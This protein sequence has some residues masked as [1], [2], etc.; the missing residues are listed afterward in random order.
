MSLW[1][2]LLWVAVTVLGVV[3]LGV[4][5]LSRGEPVSALWIIVAGWCAL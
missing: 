1:K 3:S 2:K 5:A 4:L